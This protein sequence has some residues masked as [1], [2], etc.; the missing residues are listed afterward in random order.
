[1]TALELAL[2]L[3]GHDLGIPVEESFQVAQRKNLGLSFKS[4]LHLTAAKTKTLV[5]RIIP[6]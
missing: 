4:R 1:M 6:D 3:S 5:L 2:L